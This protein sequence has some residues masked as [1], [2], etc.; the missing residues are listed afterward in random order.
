MHVVEAPRVGR[1]ATDGTERPAPPA[2]WK[3]AFSGPSLEPTAKAV[4]VLAR[5]DLPLRPRWA[6]GTTSLA[7]GRPSR[8]IAS[9]PVAVFRVRVT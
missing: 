5:Q 3:L 2:V 4:V 1:V 8:A 6:G 9:Q 7:A